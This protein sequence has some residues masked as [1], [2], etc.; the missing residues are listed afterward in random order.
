MIGV[1]SPPHPLSHTLVNEQG[2]ILL[3]PSFSWRRLNY[4]ECF[5]R[6]GVDMLG[7]LKDDY[8]HVFHHLTPR[9]STVSVDM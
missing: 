3:I 7:K 6:V 4:K 2:K 1:V 8:L 9:S 5:S